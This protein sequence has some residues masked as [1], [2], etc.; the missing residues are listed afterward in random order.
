MLKPFVVDPAIDCMAMPAQNRIAVPFLKNKDELKIDNNVSV[1]RPGIELIIRERLLGSKV[2]DTAFI[3]TI[4]Q[5]LDNEVSPNIWL[6]TPSGTIDSQS[7]V[8]TVSALLGKFNVKSSELQKLENITKVQTEAISQLV[9]TLKSL[10]NTLYESMRR[11]IKASIEINWVPIPNVEGPEFGSSGA[12]L[13]TTNIIESKIDR[14]IINLRIRKLEAEHQITAIKDLGNFASPFNVSTNDKDIKRINDSLKNLEQERDKIA[15]D[16]FVAMGNIE[17][18]VGE[19]S[20]LGL[21]DVLAIYIALW[22]MNEAALISLLDNES[23]QRMV[24]NFGELIIGAAAVRF[25]AGKPEKDIVT[26]LD[27]FESKLKN[28]LKFATIEFKNRFVQEGEKD[29]G[30]IYPDE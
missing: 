21:V 26:A 18:I 25:G 20:G 4:R 8:S 22:S 6:S 27:D 13:R 15:N 10:L 3:E 5:I 2:V 1:L 30:E 24:D 17:L 14:Q 19:V 12:I 9:R 29:G 7:L 23:F 28:V 16:A 11:V